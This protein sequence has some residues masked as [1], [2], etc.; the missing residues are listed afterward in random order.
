[1]DMRVVKLSMEGKWR[2]AQAML[3]SRLSKKKPMSK[4]L[5]LAAFLLI[6]WAVLRLALAI[7]G[8]FL[9]LLWIAAVIIAVFWI[10]GKIRGK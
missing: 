8:V 3:E 1:M 4:L 5:L 2:L 7:T 10:I 6:L 9:H